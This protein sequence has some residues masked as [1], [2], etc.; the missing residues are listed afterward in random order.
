MHYAPVRKVHRRRLHLNVTAMA[1]SKLPVA[2]GVF[3]WHMASE[4]LM[5]RSASFPPRGILKPERSFEAKKL[6]QVLYGAVSVPVYYYEPEGHQA[7]YYYEP[8]GQQAEDTVKHTG[9]STEEKVSKPKELEGTK[10][11]SPYAPS[12]HPDEQTEGG[13][14]ESASQSRH[15]RRGKSTQN[16]RRRSQWQRRRNRT[17]LVTRTQPGPLSE[18]DLTTKTAGEA[19][20]TTLPKPR[21]RRNRRNRRR[22]GRR[23]RTTE[24]RRT[25]QRTNRRPT[26]TKSGA[27]QEEDS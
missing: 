11:T 9:S 23:G 7:V 12:E 18:T 3:L 2:A 6:D 20:T 24:Q 5:G 22:R 15:P 14:G 17:T 26:T 13:V 19:E 10:T 25:T 4:C 1:R 21:R 27:E 16:K 8:G